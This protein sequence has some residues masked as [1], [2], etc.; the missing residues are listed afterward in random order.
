MAKRDMQT[1]LWGVPMWTVIHLVSFNYPNSPS[2]KHREQYA[3]W[4]ALTGQVI[5]CRCAREMFP[6]HVRRALPTR[7]KRKQ[8]K[9]VCVARWLLDTGVM[10]SRRTLS[11]FCYR[12]HRAVNATLKRPASLSYDQVRANYELCRAGCLTAAQLRRDA[13]LRRENGCTTPGAGRKRVYSSLVFTDVPSGASPSSC[14]PPLVIRDACRT[15]VNFTSEDYTSGNGMQT[16]VWGCLMWAVIHAVSFSVP[17]DAT[18]RQA[19]VYV[20]WLLSTADVLPCGYCRL[21][22]H[23]NLCTAAKRLGIENS[24]TPM[25]VAAWRD[26]LVQFVLRKRRPEPFARLCYELHRVV[27]DMLKKPSPPPESKSF[28]RVAAWY[29][30]YRVDKPLKRATVVVCPLR[31]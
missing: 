19:T 13:A 30:A 31:T 23:G 24:A 7:A 22:F 10:K 17:T 26:D 18:K 28:A 15:Q 4:L 3:R 5:P 12:L 1:A 14:A 20:N 16:R 8:L 29:D 6:L 21:N 9:G 25:T 11:H 2:R 27:N